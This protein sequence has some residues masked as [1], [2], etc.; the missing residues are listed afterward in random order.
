MRI[1]QSASI[2]N[3]NII[4]IYLLILPYIITFIIYLKRKSKLDNSVICY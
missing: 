1:I 3:E 4:I 2:S